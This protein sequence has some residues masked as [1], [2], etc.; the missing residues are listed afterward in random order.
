MARLSKRTILPFGG[1][2]NQICCSN[3]SISRSIFQTLCE[4]SLANLVTGFYCTA[5]YRTK[6]SFK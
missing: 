4:P 1:E 5:S 3:D 6:I 2:A